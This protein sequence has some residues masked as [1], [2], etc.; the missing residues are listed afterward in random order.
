M[1]STMDIEHL[2][3]RSTVQ[4]RFC[5]SLTSN[6]RVRNDDKSKTFT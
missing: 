3:I 6:F 1:V 4:T 2:Q 5:V